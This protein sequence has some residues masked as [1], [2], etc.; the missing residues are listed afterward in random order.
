MDDF[1]QCWSNPRIEYFK[2]WHWNTSCW[3]RRHKIIHWIN[4][5]HFFDPLHCFCRKLW[6]STYLGLEPYLPASKGCWR[7]EFVKVKIRNL[8]S[9]LVCPIILWRV[10]STEDDWIFG[11]RSRLASLHLVFAFHSFPLDEWSGSSIDELHWFNSWGYGADDDASGFTKTFPDT[12]CCVPNAW[13]P[14]SA[15]RHFKRTA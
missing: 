5:L 6:A 15:A 2:I 9:L 1:V 3:W 8:Q 7:R 12:P 13:R 4:H 11:W 14:F 10:S